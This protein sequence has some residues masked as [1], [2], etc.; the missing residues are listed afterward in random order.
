MKANEYRLLDECVEQGIM[1]GWQHAHKHVDNPG[2]H[3]IKDH[4]HRDVMNELCDAFHIDLGYPIDTG[5]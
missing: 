4:I 2:E 1:W 5:I 3:A